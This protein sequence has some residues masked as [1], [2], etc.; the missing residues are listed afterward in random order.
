MCRQLGY[1]T[2]GT[3]V[4]FMMLITGN[5]LLVIGTV[6]QYGSYYGKPNKTIHLTQVFCD[7]SE[8]R[9]DDCTVTTLSLQ[10]GK[11]MLPLANAAGVKCYTPDACIIPP[12][13]G[14][15]CNHGQVRL[16]GGRPNTGEGNIQFCYYGSWSAFCMLGPNEATVACRQLGYTDYDRE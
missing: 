4:T 16:T 5:I 8:D 3:I 1:E 7:G 9:L 13:N 6:V 2:Q 15:S 11:S 12:T 10:E 14:A